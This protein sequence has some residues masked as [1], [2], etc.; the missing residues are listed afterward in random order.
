MAGEAHQRV[1]IPRQKK[2]T[3]IRAKRVLTLAVTSKRMFM[4]G[5]M[6]TPSMAL[7]SC[8]FS[9]D[10]MA[11]STSDACKALRGLQ[12]NQGEKL[13]MHAMLHT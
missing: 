13:T 5:S 8:C 11:S 12:H 4:S 6:K 1:Q 9:P 2:M 3:P 7:G 10:A